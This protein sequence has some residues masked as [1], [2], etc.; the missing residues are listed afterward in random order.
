MNIIDAIEKKSV[1]GS[2]FKDRS[3]WLSWLSFLRF[4]FALPVTDRRERN[5]IKSC[6]GFDR[7][8]QPG[9]PFRECFLICG[10][11]SGK[12]FISALIACYLAIFKD[13]SKYLSVGERGVIMIIATDKNQ[14]KIIYRYVSDI[15][16]SS[17]LLSKFIEKETIESIDLKNRISI[18]IKPA[19]YRAVRGFTVIAAILEEIA[20]YRSEES[21]NPDR[22]II[23]ALKPALATI[24]ESLLIGISTPYMRS[25]VLFDQFKKH[26]GKSGDPLIWKA[27]SK[28]MNPTIDQSFINAQLKDDPSAAA[29]EWLA[30]FRS[31]VEAFMPAD[32]IDS[33]VMAGRFELPFVR[34]FSYKCFIDSASGSGS[35][36][37]SLAISHREKS[38]LVV[39]DCIR[40]RRP[41]FSPKDV[42]AEFANVMKSYGVRSCT[43]DRY[44]GEWL[45]EQMRE[46]QIKVKNAEMTKSEYYLEFL[47][48]L[49]NQSVEL[50]DNQRLIGQFCNLERRSR[51]GGKDSI[52]HP[53]G[54][55]DD[56]ANAAAGAC[57]LNAAKHAKA[58]F[59]LS[60]VDMY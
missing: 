32:A 24:P 8:R 44:S 36:S 7:F 33:V 56:V 20:F 18:V 58:Y 45:R 60:S 4:L 57:V 1:F 10:R 55:H 46:N 6:T 25:G 17:P 2:L 22:E 35:D 54:M 59:K 48:M 49:L 5:L 29:A 41:R 13:W 14:A 31:D 28:A 38:G 27:P 23:A 53:V 34:E 16:N 40:E 52:D 51:T 21:A 11:R 37:F 50:L 47:P 9:K 26:F 12:S 39:L 19:S 42:C 30:E 15:L 3:T 43:S